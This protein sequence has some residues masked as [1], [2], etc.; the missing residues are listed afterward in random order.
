EA[1]S[2][3]AGVGAA[4]PALEVRAVRL[5][6]AGD[7]LLPRRGASAP[8][9]CGLVHRDAPGG[10]SIADGPRGDLRLGAALAAA[11]MI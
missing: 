8:R 9:G 7:P 5:G 3:S 11:R 6:V 10:A 1:A 4:A 2:L